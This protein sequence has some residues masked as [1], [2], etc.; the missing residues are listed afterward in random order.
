L[1]WLLRRSTCFNSQQK[2][3]LRAFNSAS[4]ALVP[5]PLKGAKMT[6]MP[7]TIRAGVFSNEDDAVR[8]VEQLLSAGFTA[9]EITVICSDKDVE[10]RFER[11]HHQDRAGE[12]T[13]EAAMTGGLMGATLGGLTAI[14]LVASGGT[15]LLAAGGF[16]ALGGIAGS[17]MGAFMTRGIEKELANYYDQ[18]VVQGNILVAAE[19]PDGTAGGS[20]VEAARILEA[21]GANAVALPS[22]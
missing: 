17:L 10:R 12:H 11:F 18:A 16:V 22:G 2:Q 14:G 20:L 7:L 8:A 5:T 6:E 13:P 1:R 9:K 19:R 15:A 21:N 4:S 3:N